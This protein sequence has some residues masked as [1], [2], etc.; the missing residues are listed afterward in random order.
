M[1]TIGAIAIAADSTPD[2]LQGERVYRDYEEK[3]WRYKRDGKVG[4]RFW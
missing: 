4:S 2:S 3:F 1:A